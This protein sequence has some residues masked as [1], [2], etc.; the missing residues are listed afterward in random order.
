MG[1]KTVTQLQQGMAVHL[2]GEID[3][4]QEGSDEWNL[5]LESL[6]QSQDDWYQV[7]YNWES[8][9][10]T[11]TATT[12]ASQTSLALPTDFVK[13]DG[14]PQFA[15]KEYMEIR[16]EEEERYLSTDEYVITDY[17]DNHLKINP[18]TTSTVSASIRYWCR[19]TA[20]TSPAN[21][22]ICPSD[23]YLIYNASSK[24][25]FQQENPKYKELQNQANMIID[26]LMGK[27]TNKSDQIDT[28]IKNIQQ[29]KY[30]FTLGVD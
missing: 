7:D 26:Q 24:I 18:A 6:N 30:S 5:W 17:N 14:Y 16:P 19:P 27:E 20:L 2:N 9:R 8:T 3:A 28:S 10:K 25:L 1:L 13:L 29:T 23:N 22:S 12:S 11:Y 4:P 21:K 15:E